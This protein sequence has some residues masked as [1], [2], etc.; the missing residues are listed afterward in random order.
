MILNIPNTLTLLRIALIPCLILVFYLSNDTLSAYQKNLTATLIFLFAAITDWLDGYLARKLKQTSNFGA[1]I[2]PVADKLIVIAALILL[3]EL[4]RVESIVAFIIIA[5]E[6]TISSLREWMATLG[7]SGSIAVAF[8]GK[9]KTT[10]QMIAILFLLYYENI[11]FFPIAVIGKILIYF[12][13][14]LTMISMIY[15]LKIAFKILKKKKD[16]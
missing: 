11:L 4:G 5:R 12:A 13:A 1:F 3:V 15:Y 2:D 6:F 7:E 8:I 9:F 16:Y 14:L 10:M